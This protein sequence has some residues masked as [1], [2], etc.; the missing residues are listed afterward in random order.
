MFEPVQSMEQVARKCRWS[1]AE[2]EAEVAVEAFARSG[3]DLTDFAR[4]WRIR[5]SR[6]QRWVE[7]IDGATHLPTPITFHPVIVTHDEVCD[8]T[9]PHHTLPLA[10]LIRKLKAQAAGRSTSE[11]IDPAQLSL[12]LS[13]FQP[14][15]DNEP[16]LEEE[17]L[18]D[19][20]LDKEIERA[21]AER[22]AEA[23]PKPV[24]CR[25]N[26]PPLR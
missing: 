20:A 6:L 7:R 3:L 25:S 1:R 24:R 21:E 19:A 4:W 10:L 15:D 8:P 14:D 2:A 5:A 26:A 16:D 17:E 13:L 9:P 11:K 18:A 12:L 22:V 23:G